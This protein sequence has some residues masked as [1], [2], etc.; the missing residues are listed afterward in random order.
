MLAAFE[1]IPRAERVIVALDCP[2]CKALDLAVAL[3]GK[4]KWLK[5]GMTLYYSEGP[6]I[7]EI[8]K[9]LGYKVFLDLKCHDIPHQVAGAAASAVEAGADMITMHAV[10]GVPMMEAAQAAVDNTGCDTA[11]LA[12][13]VLTSMD[14][15]TLAATG[16]TRELTDQVKT[17][18]SCAAEAGLSG[19]V[20]SPQEAAMLRE[21][22]GPDALIVTPGV[23]RGRRFGRPEPCCDPEGRIRCGRFPYRDRPPHYPGCRPRR[24]VRSHR[25]RALSFRLPV[26]FAI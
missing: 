17:L 5:I 13:T 16:V 1:S 20:A 19:V 10:G 2:P 4:A 3:Q 26:H 22:L 7:V 24:S 15:A 14:A 12:I 25:C 6:A 8:F 18:A 9:L 21:L 23:R 11:T